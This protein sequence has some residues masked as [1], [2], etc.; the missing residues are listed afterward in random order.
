MSDRDPYDG[1][2]PCRP[3]PSEDNF[4]LYQQ[5]RDEHDLVVERNTQ[6]QIAAVMLLHG[7][8][9]QAREALEWCSRPVIKVHDKNVVILSEEPRCLCCGAPAS[10]V[11]HD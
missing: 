6:A 1:I 4:V 7:T 9:E 2:P 3:R 8:P 5:P 10:K 11:E